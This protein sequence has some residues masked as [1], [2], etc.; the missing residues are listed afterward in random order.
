[1]P[2]G[3]EWSDGL[4]SNINSATGRFTLANSAWNI[5]ITA[6]KLDKIMKEDS[7]SYAQTK[8]RRIQGYTSDG[9][10]VTAIEVS[11]PIFGDVPFSRRVTSASAETL[12]DPFSGVS[13]RLPSSSQGTGDKIPV[14]STRHYR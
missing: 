12:A 1:M 6:K 13:I 5:E 2:L 7:C 14:K 10:D 11:S 9:R 8:L 3:C 4:L